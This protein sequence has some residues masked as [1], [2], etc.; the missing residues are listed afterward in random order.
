M[1]CKD[2]TIY[3]P[4]KDGLCDSCAN[5]KVRSEDDLIC[6]YKGC[7]CYKIKECNGYRMRGIARNLEEYKGFV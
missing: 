7:W 1:N 2:S 6:I 4:Y 3:I 5:G